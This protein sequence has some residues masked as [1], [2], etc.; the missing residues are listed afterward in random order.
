MYSKTLTILAATLCLA[1]CHPAETGIRRST[2]YRQGMDESILARIDS[3]VKKAFGN[4]AVYPEVEPMT[5]ETMFDLASVSKC[6]GTTLSFMQLVEQGQVRLVDPVKYYFP[7]F[8]P[9]TDPDT[10][11]QVDIKVQ[12]LLTHSSGLD[13]YLPNVAAYVQEFG[14]NS[15]ESLLRYICTRTG[16]NFRPGTQQLYSCLNFITLQ[17]ILEKVTGERLCDYAQLT[18]LLRAHFHDCSHGKTGRWIRAAGTGA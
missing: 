12:D 2:P 5:V 14:P 18:F 6:V 13:A 17:F 1:A 10:G 4:K 9:W 8:Q 16:R 11:E 15:P 3:T 7:D